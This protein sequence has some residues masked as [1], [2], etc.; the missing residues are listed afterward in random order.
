MAQ[1]S[2][3][4]GKWCIRIR[5][6]GHQVIKTFQLKKDAEAFARDTERAIERGEY[7]LEQYT[8]ARAINDYIEQC[9]AGR[10]K[11]RKGRAK[12]LTRNSQ[13]KLDFWKENLGRHEL[14]ELKTGHLRSVIETQ[15][16]NRSAVSG[17]YSGE[18]LRGATINRYVSELSAVLAYAVRNEWVDRNVARNLDKEHEHGRPTPE[19]INLTNSQVETL[20][21]ACANESENLHLFALLAYE[22][23][24]RAG[25]LQKLQWSDVDLEAGHML[26]RETKNGTDRPVPLSQRSMGI[27][28]QRKR[29]R[30]ERVLSA[31]G[32]PS[33]ADALDRVF[34]PASVR[35]D[36]LWDYR[37][38]WNSARDCANLAGYEFKYLRNL[39][40][41]R[42]S[43]AGV[44][45]LQ[46]AEI[47]GHS[48]LEMVKHY[49]RHNVDHLAEAMAKLNG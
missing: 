49:A 2:H 29:E 25:E 46:I 5:K 33:P 40:V 18:P 9:N 42:A 45:P 16:R 44:P 41:T 31:N 28:R 19:Q 36:G 27:L 17:R 10:I 22:T 32:M 47:V 23:G 48:S 24:C 15:L 35:K 6:N 38:Q 39:F 3:R 14:T 30:A 43:A 26:L 20:L 7:G 11:A 37:H 13:L 34:K 21:G 4:S 8:L 12:K 1:L